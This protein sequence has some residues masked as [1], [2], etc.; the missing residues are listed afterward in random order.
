MATADT[1]K[2]LNDHLRAGY[3][4][5]HLSTDEEARAEKLLRDVAEGK[6]VERGRKR[7]LFTWSMTEGWQT[8]AGEEAPAAKKTEQCLTALTWLAKREQEGLAGEPSLYVMKDMHRL[9][10]PT[11]GR[12]EVVRALKD[13][14]RVLL[15]KHSSIVLLSG[16]YL[17]IPDELSK[18]IVI[19]DLEPPGFEELRA[20]FAE[21]VEQYRKEPKVE[22]D[23]TDED[24][25]AFARAAQGMTEN[26]A[27]LAFGKALTMDLR[28]DRSD[29]GIIQEEKQQIVRK[30][31]ILTV[32]KPLDMAEVGGLEVLKQWLDRRKDIFGEEARRHGIMAPKGV[33]LT[34]VPGCGK[35]L[36]ARG[37]ADHWKLPIL[38][39]DMGAVFGG[40]V[41][42]SE[43]NMRKA[44]ATAKAMSPC[45]LMIDE[46]EKGL[47]GSSGGGGDGGTSTRVFGTLLTWMSDKTEPVFVVATANEFDRLPPE[48][49]RKGRFD[50]LFFVDFPNTAE[51]RSILD[52][53]L[54]KAIERRLPRPD[55]TEVDRLLAAIDLDAEHDVPRADKT[56]RNG[57]AT[58]SLVELSREYTGSELEEAV[59]TAVINAFA[60]GRRPFTGEDVARGIAQT[61]PLIDTMAE[62]I[63]SL[64]AKARECTVSASR[65][66]APAASGTGKTKAKASDNGTPAVP[67][68]GGRVMDFA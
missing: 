33:L 62:K 24:V 59:K 65:P 2:K 13:A 57:K 36:C 31:G 53:H 10:H 40:L 54:R 63:E 39:L 19:I 15:P 58:G 42:D 66:D 61:I 44:I 8:A 49:L 35:S 50:E 17:S 23:V 1:L 22:I 46:I 9:L 29:I 45:I 37:M 4:L 34:G 14:V 11:Q 21:K 26:E 30:T 32:E 16:P 48:M 3:K 43:K 51:R 47:A 67:T 25:A 68:R 5:I 41:G 12:A 6:A 56:G 20:Y 18:E 27:E 60:E 7:E 28:L 38:R 55:K 64:R 52:I